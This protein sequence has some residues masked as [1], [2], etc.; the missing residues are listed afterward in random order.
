[1][2]RNRQNKRDGRNDTEKDDD[3]SPLV[4]MVDIEGVTGDE[5]SYRA[6]RALKEAHHAED[7]PI[8]SHAEG[9]ARQHGHR[10]H[11]AADTKPK[12]NSI[13]EE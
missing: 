3:E 9:P 2:L 10:G 12:D 11:P 6:A 8:G 5:R 4:G 13:E 1:M 7:R